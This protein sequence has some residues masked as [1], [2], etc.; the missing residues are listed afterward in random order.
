MSLSVSGF[1]RLEIIITSPFQNPKAIYFAS[2]PCQM[3][4][5]IKVMSEA[6]AVGKT[7]PKYFMPCFFMLFDILRN[8]FEIEIG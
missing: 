4:I 5:T 7:L 2:A 6:S 8:G 1:I 3:P